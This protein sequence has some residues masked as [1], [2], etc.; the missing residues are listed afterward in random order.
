MTLLAAYQQR[1]NAYYPTQLPQDN[2]HIG[3]VF[4]AVRYCFSAGGKRLRPALVYALADSLNIALNRVD[5]IALAIECIHTYSLIHDD[6]PAMDDDDFRRGQLACHKQFDE[7]TAILAGDALNTFA[8]EILSQADN[9]QQINQHRLRQ[10][11]VLAQCVGINGMVGGQDMDLY[12]EKNPD[13]IDFSTLSQLHSKKT[14]KLI[15]ACLSMSCL[16]AETIDEKKLSQLSAIGRLLGLFYQI[17][18]DI[19]DVTQSSQILGK[20]SQSDIVSNKQTYVSLLGLDAAKQQSK[21]LALQ[22]I[23][24]LQA[25]FAPEIDYQ[26]TPLYSIIEKIIQRQH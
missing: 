7:A 3:R 17:Q 1:F 25:F 5:D 13:S 10:I 19:L 9:S 14:G 15:E 16:A 18:D 6:L 21:H 26:E 4:E 8:F 12:G 22:L 23:A 20:P 24:S 2:R 11:H